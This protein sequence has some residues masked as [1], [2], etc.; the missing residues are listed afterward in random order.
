MNVLC[1]VS[2]TL[3]MYTYSGKTSWSRERLGWRPRRGSTPFL[4]CDSTRNGIAL[5]PW[6][7]HSRASVSSNH[8]ATCSVPFCK[9]DSQRRVTEYCVRRFTATWRRWITII[10]AIFRHCTAHQFH[11]TRSKCS[12]VQFRRKYYNYYRRSFFFII[13]DWSLRFHKWFADK[14]RVI[15]RMLE[16]LL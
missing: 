13:R 15:T 11:F 7:D 3:S 9:N 5:H 16:C 12:S 10:F 4:K 1:Q 6:I 8:L 2:R 14:R